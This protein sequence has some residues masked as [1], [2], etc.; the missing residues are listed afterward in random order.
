MEMYYH[1]M[2]NRSNNILPNQKD[3]PYP[4]VDP[5]DNRPL[6]DFSMPAPFERSMNN[7]SHSPNYQGDYTHQLRKKSAKI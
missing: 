3:L 4:I 5:L 6:H 1:D 7:A 2:Y